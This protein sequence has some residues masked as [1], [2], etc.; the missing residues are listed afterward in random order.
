M[1]VLVEV[2]SVQLVRKSSKMR[3]KAEE[4]GKEK[5]EVRREDRFVRSSEVGAKVAEAET[6]I[7]GANRGVAESAKVNGVYSEG[8]ERLKSVEKPPE[9]KPSTEEDPGTI[10]G[11][12]VDDW[13]C[14]I[15]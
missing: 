1:Q 13:Y 12:A 6:V 14:V 15:Q 9:A 8:R 3:S 2:G 10:D 4:R 5:E 11:P 7:S